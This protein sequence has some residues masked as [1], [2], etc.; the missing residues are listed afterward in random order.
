[1][2]KSMEGNK[3]LRQKKKKNWKEKFL[4]LY[5]RKKGLK[6]DPSYIA[7]KTICC[8]LV[9]KDEHMTKEIS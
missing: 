8:A 4:V 7:S 5:A 1:M 3:Y 2:K 9:C 6:L